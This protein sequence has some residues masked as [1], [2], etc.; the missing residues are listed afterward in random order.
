MEQARPNLQPGQDYTI[1]VSTVVTN[2]K[3]S[4]P[5]SKTFRVGPGLP[6][7]LAALGLKD[8][9]GGKLTLSSALEINSNTISEKPAENLKE[10][11][12]NFLN[13]LMLAN[14]NARNIR[15]VQAQNHDYSFSDDSNESDTINPLDL[16]LA[17]FHCADPFL[18]QELVSKMSM[19]Q[20]AVPLLLPNCDTQQSTLMLWAMRDLVKKFRPQSVASDKAFVQGRIVEKAI[21]MVSFVRLGESSLATSQTLN[22]LLSNPHQ[23]N[24]AFVHHDMECG[25]V[26]RRISDGL[27]EVSWYFPCG[28]GNTDIFTEPVAMANLRGDGMLFKTQISFL[29]QTSAAVFIFSDDL[30]GDLSTLTNDRN[31]AKLFLVSSSQSENFSMETLKETCRKLNIRDKNVIVKKRQNNAEFV[32]TLRSCVSGVIEKKPAVMKMVDMAEVAR[33]AGIEVDEDCGECVKGRRYAEAISN[34]IDDIAKFKVQQLPLHGKMWKEISQAEE[35][36]YRMKKTVKGQDVKQCRALLQHKVS[37]LRK[38]QH[39]ADIS[40]AMT[41]FTDG[42][43]QSRVV[44]LYFLKWLKIQLDNL[45]HQNREQQ[46][47]HSHRIPQAKGASAS[48]ADQIANCTLG[49]EHFL[50]ELGQLYECACSLPEDK[51]AKQ[52]VQHLP[53]LCAQMLLDGFPVELVDGDAANIPMKWISEVLTRLHQLVDSKSRI[54]VMTVLGVQSTGKSTLLNT[55]FGVQFAVSSG[56]STRGAFMLLIRVSEELRSELKC[57]FIMIINTEGL[58]SPE[59]AALD[60]NYEHDNELATLVIGLSDITIINISMENNTEM[61][62][63]LQIV[64]HAFFRMKEV[65][66]KPRCVFVHQNMPDMAA[67]ENNQRERTKLMDQLDEMT[68]IAGKMERKEGNTKFTDVM[69][70][71]SDK[72]NFY[73]PALWNGSQLMAPVNA[74]YSEAVYGL[75]KSLLD[76]VHVYDDIEMNDATEFNK[77]TNI[78][79]NAVK[80][81]KDVFNFKNS[82]VADAYNALRAEF[83]KWVWSFRFSMRNWH[84]EKEKLISEDGDFSTSK[85]AEILHEAA[86]TLNKEVAVIDKNLEEYFAK[87]DSHTLLVQEYKEDFRN[88]VRRLRRETEISIENSLK[89]P[90]KSREGIEIMKKIASDIIQRKIRELQGK[91]KGTRTVLTDKDLESEFEKLWKVIIYN[92]SINLIPAQDVCKGVQSVLLSHF[93]TNTGHAELILQSNLQDCG[94]EKF[95][96]IKQ[97]LGKNRRNQ[98][99]IQ[100]ICDAVNTEC[101]SFVSGKV[102]RN[103]CYK[104]ADIGDLLQI[105]DKRMKDQGLGEEGEIYLKLHVCGHAVREFRKMHSHIGDLND[106]AAYLQSLKPNLQ[107]LFKRQPTE[108]AWRMWRGSWFQRV[109]ADTQ[110]ALVPKGLKSGAGYGQQ[111]LV[112]GLEGP[113][114]GVGGQKGGAGGFQWVVV[115]EG[116]GSV[117]MDSCVLWP[118]SVSLSGSGLTLLRAGCSCSNGLF[119]MHYT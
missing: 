48:L 62:D 3:P 104:D 106:H 27:V 98:Q 42:I 74:G 83:E 89:R 56:T 34:S 116:R 51:R 75:K 90:I 68:R 39:Q 96:V 52:Q 92:L 50:R 18:Q 38:K 43:S 30:Q 13:G 115:N 53:S 65:P 73:I 79:W 29:C 28:K 71:D 44:R 77:W 49:L 112:G 100:D 32:K 35:E 86:T 99:Q 55:M 80:S 82:M 72:D 70:H 61:K 37:D 2:G 12:H 46:K 1:N 88:S 7:F 97:W 113:Q 108:E 54:L 41:N 47:T 14:V 109:G 102:Q 11:P 22:K 95:T 5:I 119:F 76:S 10:L 36:M 58:K 15:C 117:S 60:I 85:L 8:L 4:K 78:L 111:V 84:C 94:L 64:V 91:C 118:H 93:K 6:E 59:L 17:L 114:R 103:A 25:D 20:F 105:I 69:K 19:C 57:D 87:N 110:K 45:C 9:H 101:E 81:E 23:Q 40:E 66:K 63:I 16:I 21:P 24:Y 26:P 31:K 107:A 33:Q 67:Y